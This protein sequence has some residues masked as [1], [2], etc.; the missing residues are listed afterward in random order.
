[1][2]MQAPDWEFTRGTS[3]A[4]FAACFLLSVHRH[5]TSKT[6][7]H[8]YPYGN[9]G[10]QNDKDTCFTSAHSLFTLL[11]PRASLLE[12]TYEPGLTSQ[13]YLTF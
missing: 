2:E 1:M 7:V 8:S 3:L 13:H 4:G 11:E 10:E 5:L 12:L 9:H 6:T